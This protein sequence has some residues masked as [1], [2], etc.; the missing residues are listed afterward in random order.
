MSESSGLVAGGGRGG[1]GA[2][3]G[4]E[5]QQLEPW[6][7][8]EVVVERCRTRQDGR[9][10]QQLRALA[11]R[12]GGSRAMD[13][14]SSNLE[15]WHCGEVV[16]ERCRT[17]QASPSHGLSPTSECGIARSFGLVRQQD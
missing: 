3:D 15:P 10:E 12:R 17:R 14:R 13:V 7:C 5:E 1:T 16:V 2:Q 4:R 8:S 11:L 6:H 9:E